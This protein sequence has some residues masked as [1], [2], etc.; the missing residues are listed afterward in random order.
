MILKIVLLALMLISTGTASPNYPSGIVTRVVDGDTFEVQ[1][2]GLVALSLVKSP[3]MGTIDGVH[4]KEYTMERL[5]NVVVFLDKDDLA[6]INADGAIP[7]LV[8]LSGS[9][10]RPNLNRSFN[11]IIVEAG[12]AV[13]EN[14]Y[15]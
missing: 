1:G 12:F 11:R 14:N 9:D 15:Y 2:F 8:Y 7:C 10:G 13:I 3:E 5:L 4:A 6:S